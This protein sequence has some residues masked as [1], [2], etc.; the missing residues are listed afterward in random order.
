MTRY[1]ADADQLDQLARQMDGF[2][3]RLDTIR[4]ST[5]SQVHSVAWHGG[6]ADAF[7]RRWDGEYTRSLTLATSAIRAATEQLH[8]QAAEQRSASAA[9]AS[10]WNGAIGLGR[11]S[12]A[13]ALGLQSGLRHLTHVIGGALAPL[14]VL[15]YLAGLKPLGR[16]HSI[17][18]ALKNTSVDLWSGHHDWGSS[19]DLWNGSK[20]V[21]GVH[22]EGSV[23]KH[24]SA[25][26]DGAVTLGRNGL[27]A[28]GS[29]AAGVGITAAAAA[30]TS[31]GGVD[32]NAKGSVTAGAGGN[33][34]GQVRFGARRR[35]R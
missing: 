7:R 34:D 29:L 23:D 19:K 14:S 5:R 8:H 10:G 13:T 15:G 18:D 32:V 25:S 12:G 4:A 17:G 16:G 30:S 31:I 24:A 27:A 22:L 33:V 2:V 21:G 1:G 11:A 20:D 28:K 3:R 35:E 26:A 6:G 9:G